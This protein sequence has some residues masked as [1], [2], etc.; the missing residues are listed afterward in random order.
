MAGEIDSTGCAM[1]IATLTRRTVLL[2][3]LAALAAQ[4]CRAQPSWPASVQLGCVENE[5]MTDTALGILREAYRRIGIEVVGVPMPPE[6][7]AAAVN[8]GEFFGD[9]THVAGIDAVY[10]NLVRVPVALISFEVLAFTYG[11]DL[12]LRA[13]PDLQPYRIC[14]RRGLKSIEKATASFPQVSAVSQSANIFNMLKHGRCDVAVLPDTAWLELERLNI[15]GMRTQ[16]TPL[17]SWPLYH[18]VHKTHAAVIPALTQ[19][20]QEMQKSGFLAARQA[21]FSKRLRQARRGLSSE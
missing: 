16:D 3:T 5:P 12:P 1:Q 11:R 19:A 8:A 2:G 18:Y 10:P 6:R 13:W 15:R 4:V 14:I 21:D 17:Q 20:L 7:A 9:V